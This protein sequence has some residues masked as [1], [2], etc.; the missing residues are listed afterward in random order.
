MDQRPRM[1]KAAEGWA[2]FAGARLH[3]EG[4][5]ISELGSV[6]RPVTGPQGFGRGLL[7][8]ELSSCEIGAGDLT[9]AAG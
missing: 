7:P 9:A 8:R 3:L 5:M 4:G 6:G 2:S 1:Q